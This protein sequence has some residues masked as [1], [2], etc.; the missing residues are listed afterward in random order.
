MAYNPSTGVISQ[1]VSIYDVQRC[2]GLSSPD[3]ATL[4]LNANINIWSQIKPIYSTKIEQLTTADRSNPRTITGFKTGAGIKKWAGV[5]S[6]YITGKDTSTGSVASH[7]WELDRPVVDGSCA[8][9]LTDFAGYYHFVAN[10]FNV[11]TLF[12]NM[13]KLLIPSASGQS[14]TNIAFSFGFTNPVADG[15]I[16]PQVLFGDCWNFYPAVILTNGSTGSN[17]Y[18]Y[19]KAAP[20]P[21][22]AYT[23]SPVTININ[24]ADFADAIAADFSQLHSGDP[25]QSYPLRTNDQWTACVVLLSTA[26]YENTHVVPSGAT[27]VRLEYTAN[28]DRRT[29]PIKQSK[30]N[31]I[32]WMKMTVKITK[33]SGYSRR[34]KLDSIV[35]TAKMLTTTAI[36]FAI[37]ANTF[38]TPQ[39]TVTCG[40]TSGNPI[41]VNNFSSVQFSGTVGEVTKNLSFSETTWD[42]TATTVG[43]QLVNGTL[44]FH[45]SNGDFQ[46]GFSFD[47]SGGLGTYTIEDINLL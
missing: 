10:M 42:V 40:T 37:N 16:T 11:Y 4:I 29:L 43:N 36:T 25:Y 23:S 19:A 18:Q 12:G 31:N 3:L 20:N 24:T 45:H 28:V 33:V 5:Y 38:S 41:T 1:P 39:G 47:V 15:A 17:S 21:I 2:F 44:I 35:V 6:D 22:S 32:E 13:N 30:Y 46:G 26:P 27:I 14:G 9:R 7:V 34:Y 8:F